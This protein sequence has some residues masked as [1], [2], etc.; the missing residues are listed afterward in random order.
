VFTVQRRSF[1]SLTAATVSSLACG[2]SSALGASAPVHP[3][4]SG[5]DD[6][7]EIHNLGIT[8]IAFKV[9][10]EET[11]GELFIIEHATRHK[12]GPPRH[13]HPHQDE[14]FY[15]LEGEFVFEVGTDRVALRNGDSLLAPRGIPHVWAFVGDRGGKMLISY[16]PAGKMEA[17]FRYMTK[18]QSMPPQDKALFEQFDTILVGPPLAV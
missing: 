8:S 12:G 7:G 11:K 2:Q 14:W 3:V 4:L 9:S 18:T 13:M 10:T 16:T 5:Q 17:F 6:A 1:L 15:V